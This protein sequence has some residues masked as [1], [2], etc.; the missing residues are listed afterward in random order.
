MKKEV[1][2]TEKKL[3]ASK[4]ALAQ[5]YKD[6]LGSADN[7]EKLLNEMTRLPSEVLLIRL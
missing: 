6:V 5:Q 3:K 1:E 4:E 7:L 2:I